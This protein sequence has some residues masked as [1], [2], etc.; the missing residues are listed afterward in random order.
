MV[1]MSSA[2]IHKRMLELERYFQNIKTIL[3]YLLFRKDGFQLVQLFN[4]AL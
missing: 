3:V 2:N 1:D 4:R